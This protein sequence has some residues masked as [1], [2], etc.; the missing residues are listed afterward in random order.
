[1]K[2]VDYH[3]HSDYSSDSRAKLEDIAHFAMTRGLK[4]IVITDHFEPT[5]RDYE[6]TNY[7][8][9]NQRASI[10]RLNED[11]QGKLKI[12]QGVELGQ[13]HHFP[14]LIRDVKKKV[15]FDYI[16]GS[17]HKNGQDIDASELDY[18]RKNLDFIAKKYLEE[19][20]LMVQDNQFDCVGHLDL[21]KR[22][23]SRQG[24]PFSLG[25]YKEQLEEIFKILIN[26]GKGIEINTSG[27]RES[28]KDFMPDF[29]IVDFYKDLGGE[30]ITIGSDAHLAEDVGT[31]LNLAIDMLRDAGFRYI[32]VY[33][34][35]MPDFEAISDRDRYYQ[36]VI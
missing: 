29:T 25:S 12:R 32:T 18:D 27:L 11:L 4:E 28:M 33:D 36:L 15:D 34:K 10:A 7:D 16:I 31:G 6:Y 1:M 14:D 20:L 23:A 24:I 17:A 19:V 3:I 22:Y 8:P 21:I 9:I 13:P 2:L 26:N 30:I 35:G 5:R